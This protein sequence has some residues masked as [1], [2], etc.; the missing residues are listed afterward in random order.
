MTQSVLSFMDGYCERIL[1]SESG[2]L[3]LFGYE[4]IN[5][6]SNLAFL[7][8]SLLLFARWYSSPLVNF[9]NSFDVLLLTLFLGLITIGSGLWHYYG[10]YP[11]QLF[12]I[13]PIALFIHSY[14]LIFCI[15]IIKF[16]IP[17]TF[18]VWLG[19]IIV[20][21]ISDH[22]LPPDILNGTLLYLPAYVMLV[23]FTSYAYFIKHVDQHYL[24][25]GL[26]VWSISLIART[27]DLP[28]CS[29][30]PIGTHFIWHLLNAFLLYLLTLFMMNH[31]QRNYVKKH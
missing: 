19:F 23:I 27:I 10:V 14:L 21:W 28:I 29:T 12:D 2:N 15:R 24:L 30:I 31:I 25:N 5:T 3:T 22:S 13:A 9:K 7:V 6:I 8:A 16:S 20:T 26:V 18:L 11:Y 1:G 17:K 4:P